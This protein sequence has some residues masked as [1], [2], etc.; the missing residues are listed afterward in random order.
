M[1][2]LRVVSQLEVRCLQ[3]YTLAEELSYRGLILYSVSLH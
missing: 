2:G 1:H 3:S